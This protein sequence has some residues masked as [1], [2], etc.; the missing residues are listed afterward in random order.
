MTHD[1]L[2]ALV[3]SLQER[4]EYLEMREQQDLMRDQMARDAKHK[5]K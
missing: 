2:V 3:K 1:E 5:V 4:I